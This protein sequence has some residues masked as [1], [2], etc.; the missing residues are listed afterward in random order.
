[1]SE[2]EHE[3]DDDD[4]VSELIDAIGDDDPVRFVQNVKHNYAVYHVYYNDTDYF[5]V[6]VDEELSYI[7]YTMTEAVSFAEEE[8]NESNFLYLRMS[9][10]DTIKTNSPTSTRLN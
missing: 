2:F 6:F 1:M 8:I 5:I 9:N 10:G 4:Y 3:L 7:A